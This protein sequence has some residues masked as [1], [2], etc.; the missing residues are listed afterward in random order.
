ML[1]PNS[2]HEMRTMYTDLLTGAKLM[3][4][5]SDKRAHCSQLGGFHLA[6]SSH[7]QPEQHC[8]GYWQQIRLSSCSW[9]TICC[10]ARRYH[11]GRAFE[12]LWHIIFL[13]PPV[14]K[15]VPH[16]SLYVCKR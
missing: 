11:E 6:V 4:R 14:A 5:N 15:A 8:P 12:Y 16:C 1:N 7:Q 13:E 10:V 9:L 2:D 3:T